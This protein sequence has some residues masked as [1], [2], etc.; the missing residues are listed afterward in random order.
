LK[1]AF[2]EGVD[3]FEHKFQT[4]GVSPTNHCWCQKTRVIA[5]LYGIKICQCIVWFCHKA[6]VWQT[7]GQTDRRTELRLPRPR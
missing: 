1:S 2:I 6:C 4:E 5:L 7:D 3:H